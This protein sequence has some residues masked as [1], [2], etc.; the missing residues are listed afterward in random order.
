MLRFAADENFDLLL[1]ECSEEG[2]WEELVGY[3][4]LR[5]FW[6]VGSE[7]SSGARDDLAG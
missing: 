4:P 2:E 6:S 1:A 7:V 3:L 5:R